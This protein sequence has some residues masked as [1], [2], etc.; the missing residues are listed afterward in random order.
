MTSMQA[1]NTREPAFD[2]RW[3][4]ALAQWCQ[5]GQEA[6]AGLVDLYL[7][8]RLELRLHVRRSAR[9]V[10]EC[11]TEGAAVRTRTD[12]RHEIVAATGTSPKTIAH[13]LSGPLDTREL[14]LQRPLPPP[15]LDAPR[16]WRDT[17]EAW[18]DATSLSDA[19]VFLFERRAAII[20]PGQWREIHTPL[21]IRLQTP[22]PS[23]SSLLATWDHADLP[24]WAP[25]VNARSQRRVWR[26][27]SGER[28]PVVF[29]S[30]TSGVVMHELVGH[31][32][33]GDVLS[34]EGS[35]LEDG[36]ASIVG[37]PTLSVTDDP[38]RFDLPGA[39]TSD[40]E[41]VEAEPITLLSGGVVC[42]AL[43]DRFTADALGHAPGRGRRA[44]WNQAPVPRM[45]NLVVPKGQT[46][47]QALENDLRNGLVITRLSGASVE[48]RS[49]RVILR[50]EEGWELRHGRR[51]RALAPFDLGGNVLGI[52]KL[53]VPDLGDDPTPDWRLGWCLKAG[54]PLPTGSEAPTILVRSL[55]V[56]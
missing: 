21:L 14:H 40:D 5:K 37:P 23:S 48:P 15:D 19:T 11:R 17:A 2:R 6:D 45:S 16:G 50:V 41:G 51:R 33:E 28:L 39:F 49:G 54:L 3:L 20:Q 27:S 26:P 13:L 8:R 1:T 52:L 18:V 9:W 43:C 24:R 25:L 29:T 32:L 36:E 31:L 38:T 10:E 22:T 4:E 44:A 35:P 55:E 12:L 30:G 7:E 34:G 47:P 53:I 46:D 56:V 42:G